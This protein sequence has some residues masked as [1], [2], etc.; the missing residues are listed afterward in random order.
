MLARA[1]MT[2]AVT[3]VAAGTGWSQW[4]AIHEAKLGASDADS[5]DL[6]GCSV[7]MD[8]DTALIGAQDADENGLNSGA[9]YV[10]VR[11]GPDLD[12]AAEAPRRPGGF[13]T[14]RLL[15]RPLRRYGSGRSLQ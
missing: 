3:L 5:F 11:N 7:A 10:F 14:V 4:T 1:A 12:R 2:V 8:G 6:F 13:R 9:A 15:R